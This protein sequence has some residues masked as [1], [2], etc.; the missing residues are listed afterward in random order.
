MKKVFVSIVFFFLSITLTGCD[1][2]L[3]IMGMEVLNYPNRLVYIANKDN[4]LDLSG[5]EFKFIYKD[6][7]I[8]S[9]EQMA[10]DQAKIQHDIDFSKPGVYIVT[11]YRHDD[12]QIQFPIQ[13]VD[14]KY[15]NSLLE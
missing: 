8:D 1:A 3:E 6:K 2:S 15:L 13:V 12:A 7:R 11:I 4:E 9:K 14:Q 10:G 5:G